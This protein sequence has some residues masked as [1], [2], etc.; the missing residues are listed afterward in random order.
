[1]FDSKIAERIPGKLQMCG[2]PWHGLAFESSA[3]LSV[4]LPNDAVISLDIDTSSNNYSSVQPSGTVLKFRDPRAPDVARTSDQL[5]DDQESG[6][7]W[8]ADVLYSPRYKVLYGRS[9]ISNT[10]LSWLY[11]DG[12]KTWR[13]AI[14]NG[15]VRLRSALITDGNVGLETKTIPITG[16]I[17]NNP[18][19][20]IS[21]TADGSKILICNGYSG[22]GYVRY[23]PNIGMGE[24]QSFQQLAIGAES[25]TLTNMPAYD[26]YVT[27]TGESPWH[28]NDITRGMFYDES[29]T[30]KRFSV[31]VVHDSYE[32]SLG[33]NGYEHLDY[34]HLTL[35]VD[36]VAIGTASI[37]RFDV[38]GDV[39]CAVTIDGS[40]VYSGG[41]PKRAAT[42]G[43]VPYAGGMLALC[44]I[45]PGMRFIG[46]IATPMGLYAQE[47][48]DINGDIAE[49]R[50][51]QIDPLPPLYGSYNP[52]TGE[53]VRDAP[54]P[55]FW[56]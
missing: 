2:W 15:A 45:I 8:R 25:A 3:G 48:T 29:G 19:E 53:I 42:I 16:Y 47:P 35:K 10:N 12:E 7:E 46:R 20:I 13:A 49:S 50:V 17:S 30:L 56:I 28:Y 36:N 54:T 43:A 33:S 21:A 52:I 37:R 22:S 34:S 11:H 31:D 1:M 24:Y 55:V 23:Y 27:T 38:S 39:Q 6:R 40:Q 44:V 32:Y 9:T 14:S 5:A 41:W 26:D 4:K 18:L 51:T